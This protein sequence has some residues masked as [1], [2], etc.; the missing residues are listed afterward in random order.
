MVYYRR[1]YR[2]RYNSRRYGRGG[3]KFSKMNL[4]TRRNSKQQAMQIYRLNRKI[5]TIEYKTK[6]EIKIFQQQSQTSVGDLCNYTFGAITHLSS[7][8][9][10]MLGRLC[11]L[12]DIKVWFT[13]YMNPTATN[14]TYT[15]T[16]RI[17]VFQ[18]RQGSNDLPT[19]PEHVFNIT[20]EERQ[21]SNASLKKQYF[22]KAI[23]GPLKSG[24]SSE[25]KILRDFRISISGQNQQRRCKRV[26][27]KK[28]LLNVE[29]DPR[30]TYPKGYV[31]Y[32][33]IT[34]SNNELGTSTDVNLLVNLKIAYVDES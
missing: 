13:E 22:M 3:Y 20:S 6:P 2:P 9:N 17:V 29:K 33:A 4:Y 15:T 24:I 7:F 5:N 30:F 11:R 32:V 12:Q 26:S 16:S 14:T 18:L 25:F 31:G 8:L 1:R 34:S 19:L 23:Y 28:G 27:I 21:A 10:N